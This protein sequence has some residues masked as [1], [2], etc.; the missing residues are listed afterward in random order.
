MDKTVHKQRGLVDELKVFFQKIHDDKNNKG[1]RPFK[2]QGKGG[3]D[4]G[5]TS[6]HLWQKCRLWTENER[7]MRILQL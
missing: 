5:K 1:Q 6:S 7:H 3:S 2:R 4:T